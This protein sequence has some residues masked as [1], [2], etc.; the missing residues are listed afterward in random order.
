MK[1]ES[2]GNLG[3]G[4]LCQM[5]SNFQISQNKKVYF[6]DP[7]KNPPAINTGAQH[8]KK[9]YDDDNAIDFLIEKCKFITYEFENIAY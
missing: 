8:I 3:G 9:N 5:L 6:L 1:N 4:Q 2:I 7:T